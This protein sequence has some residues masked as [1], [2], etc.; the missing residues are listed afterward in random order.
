MDLKGL[1]NKAETMHNIPDLIEKQ[2]IPHF[3]I[4]KDIVE[5]ELSKDFPNYVRTIS[6]FNFDHLYVHQLDTIDSIKKGDNVILSVGTGGGKTEAAIM[7]YFSI[8]GERG[9]NLCRGVFIYPTKALSQDQYIRLKE[10]FGYDNVTVFDS[11]NPHRNSQVSER[12]ILITNPAMLFMHIKYRTPTLLNMLKN[13]TVLFVLDE[14]HLYSSHEASLIMSCFDILNSISEHNFQVLILSATLGGVDNLVEWIQHFG[15]NNVKLIKGKGKSSQMKI[16]VVQKQLSLDD[17]AFFQ[18]VESI[19]DTHNMYLIFCPYKSVVNTLWLRFQKTFHSFRHH[20]DVPDEEQ[21]RTLNHLKNGNPGIYITAKTLAQGVDFSGINY[22]IHIGLPS[23][24]AEFYQRQGRGGRS[25]IGIAHSILFPISAFDYYYC[26][27]KKRFYDYISSSPEWVPLINE[28]GPALLFKV[29]T[30]QHLQKY[31]VGIRYINQDDISLLEKGGLGKEVYDVE[32]IIFQHTPK[33]DFSENAKRIL[34][35]LQLYGSGPVEVIKE[36]GKRIGLMSINE[37]I[38]KF[39]R[40]SYVVLNN[41]AYIVHS[42][43]LQ[44][45]DYSKLYVSLIKD[46]SIAEEVRKGLLI[47]QI[48]F[49]KEVPTCEK[50][51]GCLSRISFTPNRIMY[52]RYTSEGRVKVGDNEAIYTS[53]P[54]LITNAFLTEYE[55]S[56]EVELEYCI[57]LWIH[58]I[59]IAHGIRIDNYNHQVSPSGGKALIWENEWGNV[60]TLLDL[61]K[62]ERIANSLIDEE[63]IQLNLPRCRFQL[64][65]FQYMNRE[66]IKQIIG[67]IKYNFKG[68]C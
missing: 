53:C 56:T 3:S 63:D 61:N 18:I 60:H 35:S 54:I 2:G 38:R 52:E 48:S 44:D 66:I 21:N 41:Q 31:H 57:H 8:Q 39:V 62:I 58:A 28:V 14:F 12:E 11:N 64:P 43:Q 68:D 4:I 59:S 25:G 33:F 20:G 6:G 34:H 37:V 26:H 10:W 50:L 65:H 40:G 22:I 13:N 47:S 45:G 46:S 30:L 27:D 36:G 55:H 67:N 32:D 49:E 51:I 7:S 5:P 17:E 15:N 1:T 19:L 42:F 23:T 29:S 24:V 9:S 16:T